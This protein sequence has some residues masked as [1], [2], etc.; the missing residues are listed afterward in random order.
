M[1]CAEVVR[2]PSQPL[3]VRAGSGH[4]QE[5]RALKITFVGHAGLYIETRHGSVLTDPWFNPAYFASWFPFPSN[6]DLDLGLIASPKYLYLSHLHHDHYDPEFLREHVSKDAI[7]ILPDYPLD[8][9]ERELRSLGFTRFIQTKNAQVLE[10]EGLRFMVMAQVSPAD[11]PLGDSSLMVDDGET[12]I[13]DQNDS[14]PV[15][16]ET[17]A[18]F[19]PFDA[20]FLQFSGAI[21]YPM[22]YRFPEK[23]KQVLARKKRENQ[24]ARALRYVQAVRAAHVVPSAGPPC[25]LDEELFHLN[26]FDRDPLNIFP[27][28]TV[29]IEYMREHGLDNGRLMVP[30][31]VAHVERDRFDLDHPMPEED[32]RRIFTHKREYLEE[33]RAR[34]QGLIE[35]IKASW[36]RGQVDIVSE[37]RDWLEPLIEEADLTA[38]GINGR[39]LIDCGEQSVILDFQ[40][41][42]VYPWRGEEWEYLLKVNPALIEYC[43]IHHVEDW[44]NELFLSCRFEAERKGAY[45]EYVYSFFKCLSEERIQYAEGWYSEQTQDQQLFECDGYLVQ[46]RCPHLKADLTRFGSVK[47]G[48]LTCSL[49]GWQF[50]LATGRCLTSDDRK[51]YSVPVG[52]ESER[53]RARAS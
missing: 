33:Y 8:L 26:D 53:D 15:D 6:E 40:Q 37:L 14:R 27:D 35:E 46:R 41:R 44:V 19:G 30:G 38:V 31:T 12:R 7:V 21:W 34:K 18:G 16:L 51:L 3:S 1:P 10:H 49:H 24:M 43:I 28:Q 5:E 47:D 29:F 52:E 32:V 11:G 9:L 48:V 20:H 42:K 36:P 13:L 25:F 17:L 45:N 23:M 39:V 2:T 50:E 22:V 4:F